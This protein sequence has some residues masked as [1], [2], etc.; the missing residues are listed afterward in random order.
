[1]FTT[2]Y[3]GAAFNAGMFGGKIDKIFIDN[4]EECPQETKKVDSSNS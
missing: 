3:E 1:M 4:I 2:W